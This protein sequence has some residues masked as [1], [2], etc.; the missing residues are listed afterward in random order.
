M[1]ARPSKE[2]RH[3][4]PED[5]LSAW[6]RLMQTPGVGAET[7]RRLLGHFGLPQ[8]I[9]NADIPALRDCVNERIAQAL[10]AP[11]SDALLALIERT[12][13]W[14]A[15]EGNHIL[16]LAD[17]NYPTCLLEIPDP[18]IILYAKGK[19]A[20]LSQMALAVVGSRNATAQGIANAEK[21][22]ENLSQAG[23]TIVSGMALGIDTAAHEGGLKGNGSTIAVI[24][25][26]CDLV[27]PARNRTLAHRIAEQGCLLSE[28]ALGTPAIASNFPRRNRIISG[29]ARGVLVI[30]AALQS[31]SLI[32]ARMAAEQGRD[33]FAI[34][35]S[36]H[37]PL[38]KGCH[39][40]I[41]QGAKLVESA[42]DILEELQY[43]SPA[44]I[45][46]KAS[47]QDM[48]E[49]TQTDDD[50]SIVLHAMGFDP[51]D[52]DTLAARCAMDAA[53]LSAQLLSLELAGRAEMLPGGMYRRID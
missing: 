42:Q 32:T 30:E 1:T 41:K 49:D 27:Y 15:Q 8:A 37:S 21:F 2:M 3:D 20:L 22:S 53:A 7:A 29:L 10:L 25:T 18:P 40:L 23:L 6:L 38:A 12:H 14:A 13:E 24:G 35:G 47:T 11:P 16:T 48:V 51:V 34:P 52:V 4:P 31:G 28:Y 43:V 50:S 44:S 33:M 45:S 46:M 39:Q 26:G 9:F 36:I 5:D 17:S 19:P